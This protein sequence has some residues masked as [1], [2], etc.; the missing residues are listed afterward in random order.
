MKQH[1]EPAILP[2]DKEGYVLIKNEELLGYALIVYK[3]SELYAPFIQSTQEQVTNYFSLLA[4]STLARKTN[5]EIQASVNKLI[6]SSARSHE[7]GIGA[8]TVKLVNH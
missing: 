3:L 2:S 8:T 1:S 6:Q 7:E 5:E 4:A